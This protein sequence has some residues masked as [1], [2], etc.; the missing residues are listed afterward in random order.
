LL[1]RTKCVHLNLW[2]EC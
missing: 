2:F 1:M